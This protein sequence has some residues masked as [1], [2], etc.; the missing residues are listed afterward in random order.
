MQ[1]AGVNGGIFTTVDNYNFKKI[2]GF[3]LYNA[4]KIAVNYIRNITIENCVFKE[5]G[6]G[7]STDNNM[8]VL[9]GSNVSTGFSVLKNCDIYN[10][11]NNTLIW[12]ADRNSFAKSAQ[13]INTK[14]HITR[15][16][17]VFNADVLVSR[18]NIV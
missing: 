8:I 1:D 7:N 3:T 11:T 16:I 13:I 10:N 12:N 15:V 17:P 4:P 5:N 6:Y 9:V 14:I 18:R 2:F